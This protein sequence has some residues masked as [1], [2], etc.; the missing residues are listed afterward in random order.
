[1]VCIDVIEAVSVD[2]YSEL[3]IANR[4]TPA[5][6]PNTLKTALKRRQA[7]QKITHEINSCKKKQLLKMTV[8]EPLGT[9]RVTS[10]APDRAGKSSLEFYKPFNNFQSN[11]SQAGS[12][13]KIQSKGIIKWAG[14]WRTLELLDA[15]AKK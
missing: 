1:M 6:L 7:P 8:Q 10:I 15:K 11:C 13:A 9:A 14:I 2:I 3:V 5:C 12:G 4:R